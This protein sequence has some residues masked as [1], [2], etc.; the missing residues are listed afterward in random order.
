MADLIL[1]RIKHDDVSTL[2]R[3]YHGPLFLCYVLEDRPPLVPGVKEP[4]V[5]RI[6]AGEW[7]LRP[8]DEG[9]IH[10]TYCERWKWHEAMVEIVLPGWSYVMFHAGNNH[11]QTEGCPLVGEAYVHTDNGY[12]VTHSRRAY[13]AVYPTLIHCARQGQK[14]TIIDETEKVA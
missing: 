11:E 8:R 1:E 3:L 12:V 13:K 7:E 2:G 5:S 4:G 14:L 9:R 6:P 10:A